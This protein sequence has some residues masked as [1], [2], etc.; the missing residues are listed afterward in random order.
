MILDG[1]V[2]C[3][4]KLALNIFWTSMFIL[5]TILTI[6]YFKNKESKYLE[7]LEHSLKYVFEGC[8]RLSY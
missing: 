8:Y 6:W 5:K 3:E 7:S 1:F 2:E 4:E